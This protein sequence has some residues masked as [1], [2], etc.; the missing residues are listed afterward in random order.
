MKLSLKKN[1]SYL[2]IASIAIFSLNSCEKDED[3]AVVPTKDLVELAMETPTLGTLV[4]AITTAQ[5]G[6]ALEAAGPYTV[7]APSNAAFDALGA[8]VLNILIA[9]PGVLA[10]VLLYHVVNGKVL[11]TDLSNKSVQT[12]L[13]GKSIAV[14][15]SGGMITLNGLSEVTQANVEAT[16][17]VVHIIDEVLLPPGFVL[18]DPAPT[19]SIVEIASATPSLSILVQALTKFPDLVSALSTD[20]SYTVFA[21]TNDAFVA[22][23]G[24]IGQTGLDDIPESV[25]ERLLKYHVIAGA[26]L[27]STDLT[28]GQMAATL[29]SDNDKVTVGING[30]SVTINAAAVTAANV[31]A[32]MVLYILLMLFLVPDSGIKSL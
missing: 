31:E 20:G 14:T 10:D 12:L 4:T 6:A 28:D 1:L 7:F 17:G 18:P 11:S 30:M 9:N 2:A 25:I 8:D 24:V 32:T 19:K 29:L 23:L 16:N 3:P 22:L 21:P 26:S 5:L 15:V 27:M 13:S